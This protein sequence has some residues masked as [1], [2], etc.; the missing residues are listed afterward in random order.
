M[1]FRL[2]IPNQEWLSQLYLLVVSK[3]SG[4]TTLYS[5]DPLYRTTG[6]DI[7]QRVNDASTHFAPNLHSTRYSRV[8]ASTTFPHHRSISIFLVFG[9]PSPV[10]LP[11]AS[12]SHLR[13][14]PNYRVS[15]S[16]QL[17]FRHGLFTLWAARDH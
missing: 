8:R 11:S 13:S 16:F 17:A 1:L 3:M 10:R 15:L 5:F 9:A 4:F 6:P 2:F 12:S 7:Y 14:V